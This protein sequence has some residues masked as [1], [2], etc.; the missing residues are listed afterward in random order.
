MQRCHSRAKTLNDLIPPEVC[1]RLPE[2]LFY[3]HHPSSLNSS[4]K[5]KSVKVINWFCS[6]QD[7]GR[8]RCAL[9]CKKKIKNTQQ[10]KKKSFSVKTSFCSKT[11]KQKK[12][13]V[14]RPFSS[15]SAWTGGAERRLSAVLHLPAIANSYRRL[16]WR[17][18]AAVRLKHPSH[19]RQR[20]QLRETRV[21]CA[22]PPAPLFSPNIHLQRLH[23]RR[24]LVLQDMLIGSYGGCISGEVWG[25][26]HVGTPLVIFY[27]RKKIF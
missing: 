8:G 7:W 23:D 9:K 24:T 21:C 16:L 15:S 20:W 10:K 25:R 19:V 17:W 5:A 22:A 14:G 12:R 27:F 2:R 1:H 3:L 18:P 6:V 26:G 4:P 13:K 11:R